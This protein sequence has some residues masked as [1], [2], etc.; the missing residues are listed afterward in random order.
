ML[1][2]QKKISKKELKED[3]FVKTMMETRA[4]I[5]ENSK[6]VTIITAVILIVIVSALIYNYYHAQTLEKSST[7]LGEAQ[8]EYQNM[9]LAKAE[10]LLV[11]LL[12]EYSG[13]NA[14]AQG[15]FLLGN[16]YYQQNK[17][18]LAKESYMEFIESY[19][20]SEI[21]TASGYAGYAA[22]LERENNYTEAA[23]YYMKA[24]NSNKDFIEAADYL[25]LAALNYI[26]AEQYDN[27]RNSLQLLLDNYEESERKND[28]ESKLIL[29]G[30][31]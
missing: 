20:G 9:S 3:K 25:Y 26:Q 23:E 29:I 16:I 12:D 13:S 6:N 5:E 27:A 31:K 28:A 19:S 22:C 30:K 21:L 4:Y 11:R 14:A 10:K 17:N 1:K 7:L 8:I 2:P 24:R 18:E 15:N